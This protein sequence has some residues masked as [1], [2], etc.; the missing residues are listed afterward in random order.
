MIFPKPFPLQKA[1]AMKAYNQIAPLYDYMIQ[2]EDRLQHE[3]GFFNHLFREQMTQSVL[4]VGCG[5]GGHVLH[6]AEM[7]LNVTGI[8]SSKEM[9]TQAKQKAG[10]MDVDVELICMSLDQFAGKF[11]EKF[12]MV[13]CIGNTLPHIIERAKLNQ[14]FR[15][16]AGALNPFGSVVIHLHNYEP[17]LE[18]Q[19][20]DFPV[21]STI[22]DE[23]E[24]VFIRFYDYHK[25]KLLFN[26][27]SAVKENGEWTSKSHSVYHYPWQYSE[28]KE[29]ALEAGFKTVMAYGNFAFADFVPAESQNLILV[30]DFQE[31]EPSID[32][33]RDKG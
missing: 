27:I 32:E 29:A 2:W 31:E 26:L 25:D 19:R 1:S 20:R 6:W 13:V 17:L 33:Y 5:T 18:V 12:D 16:M 22:R 4:D 21:K 14:F 3:D 8:D 15:N 9:I 30:C 23:K 10:G 24:Y 7:G 28:L 11:E